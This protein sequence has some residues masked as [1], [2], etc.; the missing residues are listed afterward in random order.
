MCCDFSATK[1]AVTPS[2]TITHLAHIGTGNDQRISIAIRLNG[3]RRWDLINNRLTGLERE[4]QPHG[5]RGLDGLMR[6]FG[7]G[8][9]DSDMV[10]IEIAAEPALCISGKSKLLGSDS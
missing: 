9:S 8:L 5:Y 4:L 7:F 6:E 1:R 3:V 2:I 10:S